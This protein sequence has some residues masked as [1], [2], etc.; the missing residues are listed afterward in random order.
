MSAIAL[1]G[2]V[3]GALTQDQL[4]KLLL[5]LVAFSAGSLLSVRQEC[6]IRRSAVGSR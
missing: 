4:K 6:R 3:S 1:A 2:L 5:P